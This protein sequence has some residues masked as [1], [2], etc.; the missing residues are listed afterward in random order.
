[1]T[2]KNNQTSDAKLK[3]TRHLLRIRGLQSLS[4]QSRSN[5]NTNRTFDESKTT[6]ADL[7][8]RFKKR[9]GWRKSFCVNR[10]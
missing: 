5:S 2:S 10:D 9:K 6:R 7:W 1:M 3:E 8:A 4:R